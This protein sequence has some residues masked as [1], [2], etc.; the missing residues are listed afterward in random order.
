MFAALA[1]SLVAT[2]AQAW[3]DTPLGRVEAVAVLQGLNVELLTHPSAT[4]TLEAW[5]ASHRLAETPKVVARPVRLDR[6]AGPDVRT[7]L[8][9]GPEETVAYRRVQLVCGGHVLSEAD[10]WYVPARLTPEM[11]RTLETTDTPFGRAVAAL[12]FRRETL[13]A[14]LL[15]RP[16]PQGWET[17]ARLP[18]AG[19]APLAIPAHVLEHRAVLSTPA[20]TPFSLVV[21]SYTAEVLAFSPP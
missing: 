20:G 21:E 7:A 18:A 5:C 6:S 1:V 13:S 2:A 8:K 17:A 15:F 4:A 11:N 9:V 16:L 14:K 3:P 19:A 12:D 10:N